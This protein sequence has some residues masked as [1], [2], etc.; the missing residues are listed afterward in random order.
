MVDFYGGSTTSTA[1]GYPDQTCN[2][3]PEMAGIIENIY[4]E[5]VFT[6]LPLAQASQRLLPDPKSCNRPRE[7]LSFGRPN[8]RGYDINGILEADVATYCKRE[9]KLGGFHYARTKANMLDGLIDCNDPLIKKEINAEMEKALAEDADARMG[10]GVPALAS[11]CTQGNAAGQSGIA[12]GTLAAPIGLTGL[13][14]GGPAGAVYAF[15]YLLLGPQLFDEMLL[16]ADGVAAIVPVFLKHQLLNSTLLTNAQLNGGTSSYLDS[17]YCQAISLRC[18]FDVY[19]GNCQAAVGTF[20]PGSGARPVY[21]VTWIKRKYF[22]SAMGIV[23]SERNVRHGAGM[24]SYSTTMIRDGWAVTH[25]EAVA[26]GY[27][28][29]AV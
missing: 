2:K 6:K 5:Q 9:Y 15:T 28:Y 18:G 13:Q 3:Y 23:M 10:C 25:K 12:L 17:K 26:V 22:D 29:A 16:G 21:R 11:A 19:S 4:C 1:S 7:F 24:D 27:V 20:N 8:V 14:T